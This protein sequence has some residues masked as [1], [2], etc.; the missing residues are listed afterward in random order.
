[1]DLSCILPCFT[2]YLIVS[3]TIL[4]SIGRNDGGG[5]AYINHMAGMV[6]ESLFKLKRFSDLRLASNHMEGT[7][8]PCLSFLDNLR[9]LNL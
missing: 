8:S 3:L 6:P 9:F 2:L 4:F 5:G 7:T 1:M